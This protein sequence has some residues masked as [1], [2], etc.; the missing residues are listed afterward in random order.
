MTRDDDVLKSDR[1]GFL[2]L[3]GVGVVGGSAAA[4][5]TVVDAVAAPAVD[6][7]PTSGSYRETEHIRRY[8]ELA[9]FI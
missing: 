7:Q 8:Y 4:V 5:T 3:A 1:R 9:K 2:R 6:P